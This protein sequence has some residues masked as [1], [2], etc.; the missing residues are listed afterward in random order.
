MERKS[1]LERAFSPKIDAVG[2]VGWKKFQ[3]FFGPCERKMG[4][5]SA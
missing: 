2:A 3:D 4:L 5:S 1:P